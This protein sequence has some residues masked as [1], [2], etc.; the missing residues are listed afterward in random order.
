MAKSLVELVCEY[1]GEKY[2]VER[3]KEGRSRFCSRE[4]MNR[5]ARVTERRPC[6][7][8]GCTNEVAGKRRFCSEPCYRATPKRPYKERAD[9]GKHRSPRVVRQCDTCGKDV[10]RLA[11]DVREYAFCSQSCSQLNPHRGGGR[12]VKAVLGERRYTEEGYV[13]VFVGK[14]S[15]FANKRGW[16]AEHR[17]VRTATRPATTPP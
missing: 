15:H 14:D 16:V 1:C 4:C 8:D 3:R 9:K 6:A 10:E 5:A 7:R 11:T 17:L 2:E 12:P 13:S